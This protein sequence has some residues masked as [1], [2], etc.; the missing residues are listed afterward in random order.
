[1]QN[2]IQMILPR[3]PTPREV[4]Q[5]KDEFR[6][7]VEPFLRI[8]LGLYKRAMPKYLIHPD[9]HLEQIDLEFTPS[10]IETE[11]YA[12]AAIEEIAR[13]FHFPVSP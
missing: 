3:P 9:G 6:R 5:L 13:R 8:K 2:A 11:R 7:A 12:D 10:M 1:M 4:E